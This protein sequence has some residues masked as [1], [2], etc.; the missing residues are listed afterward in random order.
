M[1]ENDKYIVNQRVG[2]IRANNNIGIDYPFLY[3]L[4]NYNKFLENLRGRANS[5]VQV[6]LSTYEIK[7]SKFILAPVIINKQFDDIVKP[8]FKSIFANNLENERLKEVR[9]SLLSKLMS[10]EIEV[11]KI[12]T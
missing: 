7:A 6:N 3:L 9:D 8:L 12:N 5:G 2:L 1:Y 11:S 10:G 4:T